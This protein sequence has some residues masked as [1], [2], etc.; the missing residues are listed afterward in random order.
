MSLT[1]FVFDGFSVRVIEQDG[2]PWFVAR[3]VAE[4]LGY[5]RTRDAISQHCKGGRKTPLPSAGGVQD[6][7]I[8]PERD[9]YRLIMRSK[10]PS[11]E[12]F[13]EWVVGEV[14]P[15]IRK[16]G[17]YGAA[18]FDPANPDHL[19]GML[20]TYT[21]KVIA[22][23]K[24]VDEQKPAV[25]FYDAF[26]N[27]DGLYGLQNAGRALGMGPNKFVQWLKRE[28]LFYQGGN[29]VAKVAYIQRG[30]FEVKSTVVD[31]RSFLRT[32]VTPKGLQYLAQR[33]EA[34]AA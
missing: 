6:M 31:E 2:E 30:Y 9:V 28:H 3:D 10:L 14:L 16:T 7:T 24:Q 17:G 23:E 27:S 33:L 5:Q 22:L 13:E 20:L 18:S 4:V 21:E 32:Y 1:P 12:R 8:I 26:A 29:L 15:S 25:A 34:E 19:R 11:A